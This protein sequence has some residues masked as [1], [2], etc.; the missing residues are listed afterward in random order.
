MFCDE[1]HSANRCVKITDPRARKRFL[2]SNGH[3]FN[4]FEKSHVASSCKQNYKCNKCNGRHHVLICTFS[5]P[6]NS[7]QAPPNGQ[8]QY[9]QSAPTTP[10]QDSTSNKFSTNRNNILMQTATASV[11]N[12]EKNSVPT[13]V[14]VIFDS[15][16]QR[17]YVNEALCERLKLQ[18]IRSERIIVK[19]FGNNKFRQELLMLI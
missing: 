11:S 10:D 17:T 8:F 4:C 9:S 2:S 1:N 12:L 3:C 5:K 7:S 14:K 15:G 16:S 19:T 6:K 18:V 13:D